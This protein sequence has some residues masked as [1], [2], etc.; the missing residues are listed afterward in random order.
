MA[1]QL[2]DST[3]QIWIRLSTLIESYNDAK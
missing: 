2:K 3:T 1:T